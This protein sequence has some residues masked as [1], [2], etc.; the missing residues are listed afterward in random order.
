LIDTAGGG[1][2]RQ[3][4]GLMKPVTP[5]SLGR[6]QRVLRT[7]GAMHQRSVFSTIEVKQ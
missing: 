4:K 6:A 2:T 3:T 7:V 1:S 5:N